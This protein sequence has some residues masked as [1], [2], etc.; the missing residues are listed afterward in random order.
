[1]TSTIGAGHGIFHREDVR[2]DF[3][4]ERIKVA[5][6]PR[7]KGLLGFL[8]AEPEAMPQDVVGLADELHVAVFD[9]VVNNLDEMAGAVGS[10]VG[11]ARDTALDR[12]P[13]GRAFERLAGLCVHLGGDRV[14]DRSEFLPGG[15]RAAGHEG[16]T[17]ARAL[18][19]AGDA[20]ADEAEMFGREVFFAAD[21]VRPQG[22]AAVDDDVLLLEQR[23]QTVDHGIGRP[24][25]LD[26]DDDFARALDRGDEVFECQRGMES[27]GRVGVFFDEFLGLCR[28]AVVDGNTETMVGDV[29]REVLSHHGEADETDVG[30][31]FAH[32]LQILLAWARAG[33]PS[34]I[35][36]IF[37]AAMVAWR[38]T[39]SYVR[40]PMCGVMTAPRHS[41]SG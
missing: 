5:S 28:R 26:E 36:I 34:R 25:G 22:V 16:R 9:A 35:L 21:G 7:S 23:H 11:R 17:K 2:R 3:D 20:G 4:E 29:Q 30:E 19:A 18:F 39:L 33:W 27:A 12:F 15:F 41:S 32:V 31:F 6:I 1:M 37:C 8:H 24:A 10:D 14:P 13:G 40:E 38:T